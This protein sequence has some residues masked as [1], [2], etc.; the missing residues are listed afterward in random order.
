[1][2]NQL[3][4]VLVDDEGTV[5]PANMSSRSRFAGGVDRHSYYRMERM[6]RMERRMERM[7]PADSQPDLT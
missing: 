2:L 7:S 4:T 1:M 3:K 5:S 6:E